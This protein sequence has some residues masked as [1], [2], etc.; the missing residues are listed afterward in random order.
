[1]TYLTLQNKA[2]HQGMYLAY[3]QLPSSALVYTTNGHIMVRGKI[4]EVKTIKVQE[5]KR[6]DTHPI[7]INDMTWL[8]ELKDKREANIVMDDELLEDT[9]VFSNGHVYQ[10]LYVKY[11]MARYPVAEWVQ[12]TD[13]LVALDVKENIIG[14]IAPVNNKIEGDQK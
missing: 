8:G 1:M 11:I 7:L 10:K 9:E 2:L 4:H 13:K 6:S 3:A 12:V 14:I 5:D